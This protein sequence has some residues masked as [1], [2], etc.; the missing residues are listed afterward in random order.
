ME[1]LEHAAAPDDAEAEGRGALRGIHP[2]NLP[3]PGPECQVGP[4]EN[5]SGIGAL[6]SESETTTQGADAMKSAPLALLSLAIL[7]LALGAY[8]QRHR[9]APP[10][11]TITARDFSLEAPD[12]LP[13]GAVTLRLVNQ[14]K[15]FHHVWIA[16]LEGGHTVDDVLAALRTPG[17]PPEWIKDAGGPNAPRPEGGENSATVTLARGSYI[18]AC[19]IPSAD[20]IPHLMKGMVR[21]LTV[22]ETAHPAAAPDADVLMTLRDYSFFLSRP[23]TPGQHVIEVR[24]EGTQWHEFELVQLAPGKTPRDV[25]AFVE[26]GIGSPPGLPIGGVSPLMPGGVS[27]FHAEL[28]AGRYALICFLP[29]RKDGKQHFEHGMVQEF[30]VGELAEAFGAN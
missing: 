15:E 13:E 14:G 7:P 29:D 3:V 12:T 6:H 16:R 27:Y 21:P 17:P 19:L 8:V 2:T 25:V 23:L 9:E 20:G 18:V 4:G 1:S 10:T 24:N 5:R 11:V 26:H 30:Q 28:Q 22:V